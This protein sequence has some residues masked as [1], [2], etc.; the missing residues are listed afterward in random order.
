MRIYNVHQSYVFFFNDTATTDI[1][2]LSLHDALPISLA[3]EEATDPSRTIPKALT[4]AVVTLLLVGLGVLFF[5]PA[6]GGT[7]QLRGADDPLYAAL[8][9]PFAYGK[10]GWLSKTIGS[11]ALIGLVA[12]FFSVVYTSS[13]QPDS[14]GR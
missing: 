8:T 13:L 4:I 11:G 14:L 2:T 9:S 1:Y 5:G 6:G 10:Q 12:T 3:A 7:E